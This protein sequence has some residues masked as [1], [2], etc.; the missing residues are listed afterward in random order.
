M[1]KEALT[2]LA[3][4]KKAALTP[5]VRPYPNDTSRQLV[6]LGG[7]QS[8]LEVPPSLRNHS[9]ST[10]DSM[11]DGIKRWDSEGG[12]SVWVNREEHSICAV[13]DDDRREEDLTLNLALSDEYKLLFSLATSGGF[14]TQSQ[15]IRTIRVDL[16]DVDQKEVLLTTIRNLKFRSET[17]GQSVQTVGNESMG[18]SVT[19]AIGGSDDKPL[20]REVL[21]EIPV[22][23]TFGEAF[24]RFQVRMDLETLPMAPDDRKFR[25]RPMPN[26]I[27]R[28]IDEALDGIK[29]EITDEIKTPIYFGTP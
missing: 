4:L 22:F 16:A 15:L 20:D 11:I 10:V 8:V 21:V 13:L 23:S 17:S 27:S 12:G 5:E 6:F 29:E 14:L 18:R 1:L 26:E 7:Q 2:Y 9:V 19:A 24:K 25:F 3:D 28:I